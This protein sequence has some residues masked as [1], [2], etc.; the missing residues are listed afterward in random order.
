MTAKWYS[1]FLVAVGLA[2]QQPQGHATELQAMVSAQYAG[3]TASPLATS[4][5]MRVLADGGSAIDAAIAAQM[6]WY[7]VSLNQGV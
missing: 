5:A 1:T 2:L 3:A 7:L 6:E 4:A